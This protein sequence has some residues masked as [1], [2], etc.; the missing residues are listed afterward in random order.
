MARK[1]SLKKP[2]TRNLAVVML[3]GTGGLEG[4]RGGSRIVKLTQLE[5][6]L[7]FNL[8]TTSLHLLSSCMVL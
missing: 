2:K 1:F 3:T 4:K 7:C 5:V 8:H 6:L